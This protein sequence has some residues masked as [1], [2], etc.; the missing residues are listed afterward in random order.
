MTAHFFSWR[1]RWLESV[2]IY[3]GWV[4]HLMSRGSGCPTT[5]VISHHVFDTRCALM[6]IQPG[7]KS[8]AAHSSELTAIDVIQSASRRRKRIS[9][10]AAVY[11]PAVRYGSS[12]RCGGHIDRLTKRHL[13]AAHV[14]ISGI[15][16][17]DSGRFFLS[18]LAPSNFCY[19]TVRHVRAKLLAFLAPEGAYSAPLGYAG[20]C[21]EPATMAGQCPTMAPWLCPADSS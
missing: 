16:V 19:R 13:A 17:R 2:R 6:R 3:V 10:N 7:S 11:L 14:G 5:S 12:L 4:A 1:P 21:V 15:C 20:S 9:L 8:Q 18:L